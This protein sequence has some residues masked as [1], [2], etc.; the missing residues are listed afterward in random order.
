[1]NQAIISEK[2]LEER[3]YQNDL[4]GNHFYLKKGIYGIPLP[5]KPGTPVENKDH[6]VEV[7][8]KLDNVLN[9]YYELIGADNLF[10]KSK[11]PPGLDHV[12]TTVRYWNAPQMVSILENYKNNFVNMVWS[13]SEQALK[14]G[15]IN[16]SENNRINVTIYLPFQLFIE[17]LLGRKISSTLYE[18]DFH[19]IMGKAITVIDSLFREQGIEPTATSRHNLVGLVLNLSKTT[20]K[21][22]GIQNLLETDT[23]THTMNNPKLI[24]L[25]AKG[26]NESLLRVFYAY[27]V[28]PKTTEEML[29][30]VDVPIEMLYAIWNGKR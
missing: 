22:P 16:Y 7:A 24:H 21:H 29:E 3:V 10:L 18:E 6:Y 11:Y 27:D 1:M 2:P 12:M 14:M 25:A 4:P 28:Y 23:Q 26:V 20:I 5:W 13:G 17:S 30:L 9:K 15:V 19:S 8:V